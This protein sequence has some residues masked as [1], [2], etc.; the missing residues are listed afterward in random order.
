MQVFGGLLLQHLTFDGLSST[1]LS[2]FTVVIPRFLLL[3][4]PLLLLLILLHKLAL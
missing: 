3:F 2:I 1:H 4:F